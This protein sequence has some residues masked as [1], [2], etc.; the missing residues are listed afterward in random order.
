MKTGTSNVMMIKD[1]V[2]SFSR[3]SLLITAII[4]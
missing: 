1:F 2:I 3:N 4:L